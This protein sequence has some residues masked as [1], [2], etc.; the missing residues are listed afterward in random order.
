MTNTEKTWSDV[1]VGD[2]VI[3]GAG[4]RFTVTSITDGTYVLRGT[5]GREFPGTPKPGTPV[6]I[7]T[8]APAASIAPAAR[9]A[10]PG[11]TLTTILDSPAA[12]ADLLTFLLELP[13]GTRITLTTT[14]EDA[15]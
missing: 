4:S 5:D 10:G 14:Q 3:A 1:R 6:T 15:R 12:C 9:L 13:A 2:V 11:T 7:V 8:P